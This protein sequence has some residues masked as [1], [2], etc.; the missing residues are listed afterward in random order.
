MVWMELHILDKHMITG[1]YFHSSPEQSENEKMTLVEHDLVPP[2][3][4]L[5]LHDVPDPDHHKG[6]P[7]EDYGDLH[8]D[9]IKAH[10]YCIK[11]VQVINIT[12]SIDAA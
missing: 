8:V 4:L 10:N 9:Q 6:H 11:K 3:L 2:L 7:D 12:V 5:P 1:F